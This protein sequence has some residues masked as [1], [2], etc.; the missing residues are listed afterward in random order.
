MIK[1]ILII[2]ALIAGIL[3][4]ATVAPPV[5]AA[6]ARCD[7]PAMG[8]NE[9]V[10]YVLCCCDTFNGTCCGYTSFCSGFVPGCLCL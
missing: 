5:E 3:I 2:L 1:S 10:G 7:Q 9:E 6:I 4:L 8:R